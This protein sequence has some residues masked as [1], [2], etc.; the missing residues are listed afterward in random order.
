G[1]LGAALL[2]NLFLLSLVPLITRE[3]V[4]GN[5]LRNLRVVVIVALA[6]LANIGLHLEFLPTGCPDYS[7]RA[8]LPRLVVLISVIGGRII[9]AFTRNWLV[10]QGQSQRLP[11][12]FNGFDAA[13]LIV[14]VISLALWT[15]LPVSSLTG[16]ALLVAGILQL[17]RMARWA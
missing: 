13:T 7:L 14:S 1:S 8:A 12:R 2:D 11:V 4:T 9:P 17:G 10:Q 6:M 16:M 5:N 15:V 3:L